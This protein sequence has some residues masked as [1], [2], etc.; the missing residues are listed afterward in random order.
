LCGSPSVQEGLGNLE[1]LLLLV[2]PGKH[3][4]ILVACSRLSVIG[5]KRKKGASERRNKEG[6]RQGT[7]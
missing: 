5:D 4:S 7:A 3:I 1:A 6:L 2:H